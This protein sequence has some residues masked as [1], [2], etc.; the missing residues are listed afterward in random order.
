MSSKWLDLYRL[1]GAIKEVF[2]AF[3]LLKRTY[4]FSISGNGE[5]DDLDLIVSID[6]SNYISG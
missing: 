6:P 5:W 4:L 3:E 2:A 1:T